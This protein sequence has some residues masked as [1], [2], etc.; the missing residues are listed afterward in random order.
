MQGVYS[1]PL[2]WFH[3]HEKQGIS[4]DKSPVFKI[5]LVIEIVKVRQTCR[6]CLSMRIG[7]PDP[8]VSAGGAGALPVAVSPVP[9]KRHARHAMRVSLFLI[10]H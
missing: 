5:R 9:P 3:F 8:C 6:Y 1:Y 4:V 2:Y 7:S 10:T